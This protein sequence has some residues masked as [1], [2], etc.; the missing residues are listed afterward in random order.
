MG[1]PGGSDP[2]DPDRSADT[3][4]PDE[5]PPGEPGDGG[6]S[7][8]RRIER[9]GSLERRITSIGGVLGGD[10]SILIGGTRGGVR[11][12]GGVRAGGCCVGAVGRGAKSHDVN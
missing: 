6:G 10:E 12:A 9:V 7:P 11:G 5:L 8:R 3:G 1:D 2:A 4:E